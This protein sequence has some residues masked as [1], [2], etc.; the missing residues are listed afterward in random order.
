MNIYILLALMVVLMFANYFLAVTNFEARKKE[1]EKYYEIAGKEASPNLK[2]MEKMKKNPIKFL[3]A[4]LLI[5]GMTYGVYRVKMGDPENVILNGEFNFL[6]G[7]MFAVF[8]YADLVFL[9]NL[10]LFKKLAQKPSIVEGK[11]KYENEFIFMTGMLS[12][13]I[14]TGVL[15]LLFLLTPSALVGG[16][17][18]GSMI[19]ILKNGLLMRRFSKS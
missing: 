11:V 15:F 1:Y 12:P 18:A 16:F 19:F 3:I 10:F 2:K 6:V 17:M 7:F 4:Y 14:V 5:L 9:T 13:T 8:G